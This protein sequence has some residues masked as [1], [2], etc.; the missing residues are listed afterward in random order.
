MISF[1]SL[2]IYLF[3]IGIVSKRCYLQLQINNKSCNVVTKEQIK[4]NWN[5]SFALIDNRQRLIISFDKKDN[6]KI[7]SNEITKGVF[8][9]YRWSVECQSAHFQRFFSQVEN[10]SSTVFLCDALSTYQ[11]KHTMCWSVLVRDKT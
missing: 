1:L 6:S 4:N 8:V 3:L 2:S 11:Y 7:S 5:I 9:S 10:I